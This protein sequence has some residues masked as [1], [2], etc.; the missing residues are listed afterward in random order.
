MPPLSG[1]AGAQPPGRRSLGRFL[2]RLPESQRAIV[3]VLSFDVGG[4]WR[5][6]IRPTIGRTKRGTSNS[7]QSILNCREEAPAIDAE[8]KVHS[9]A[10]DARL[11]TGLLLLK[12]HG[13]PFANVWLYNDPGRATGSS[14][15]SRPVRHSVGLSRLRREWWW[16][17]RS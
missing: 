7:S 2:A 17:W 15:G 16:G 12:E 13:F 3:K 6:A 4:H 1:G 10:H 8:I 11:E 9:G 14:L 5:A